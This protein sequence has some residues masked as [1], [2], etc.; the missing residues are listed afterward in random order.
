M[1]NEVYELSEAELDRAVG[2]VL[3]P[4][5]EKSTPTSGRSTGGVDAE[6]VAAPPSGN[7]AAIAAA[8]L[9]LL[10]RA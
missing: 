4:R 3:P 1:M 8:G 5:S 7:A 6:A 9:W 10:S 2:G